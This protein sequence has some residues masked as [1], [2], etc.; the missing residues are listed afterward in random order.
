ML[1]FDFFRKQLSP[2]Q[3]LQSA[4]TS[5]AKVRLQQKIKDDTLEPDGLRDYALLLET[6]LNSFRISV[7]DTQQSRCLWLEDYRFSS[8]FFTEQVLEKLDSIYEDHPLLKAGFWH[9]IRVSFKKSAIYPGAAAAV[10][11]GKCG[12]IFAVCH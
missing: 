6:G 4:D 2:D 1:T 5:A 9:S 8:V 11:Q 10:P 3:S 12:R 7:V